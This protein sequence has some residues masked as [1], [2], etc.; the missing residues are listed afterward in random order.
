MK[1]IPKDDKLYVLLDKKIDSYKRFDEK[2]GKETTIHISEDAAQQTRI[3]TVMAI[4]PLVK[5]TKVG[6][7]VAMA[8][9]AGSY[10]NIPAMDYRDERHKIC[11]ER[12]IQ[13]QVGEED[14]G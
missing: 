2:L 14:G 12:E 1:I 7:R 9:W 4:G 6:D 3:G 13:F 11:T 10:I 5:N 8:A